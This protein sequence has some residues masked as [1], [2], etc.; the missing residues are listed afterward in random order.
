[1]TL[2]VE[3]PDAKK[4]S[5]AKDGEFF[6]AVAFKE[7]AKNANN[8]YKFTC[9]E[10]EEKKEG[11]E[12]TVKVMKMKALKDEAGNEEQVCAAKADEEDTGYGPWC[13]LFIGGPLL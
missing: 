1:M 4:E 5:K 11:S 8:A 6:E 7:G 3:M 10:E 13:I 12:E 2:Y 9:F